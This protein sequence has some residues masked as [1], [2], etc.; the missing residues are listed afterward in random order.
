MSETKFHFWMMWKDEQGRTWVNDPR[1]VGRSES[2]TD[3][4]RQHQAACGFG[5]LRE[6]MVKA[7]V[8]DL[9]VTTYGG[10]QATIAHGASRDELVNS[11]AL[12]SRVSAYEEKLMS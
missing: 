2:P 11:G 1:E 10:K 6:G 4:R 3:A 9:F 5:W 8:S 12:I 7:E